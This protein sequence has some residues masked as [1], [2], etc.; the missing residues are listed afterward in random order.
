MRADRTSG[1]NDDC[2]LKEPLEH[3]A[4]RSPA[5]LR[6]QL[7][8]FHDEA[9]VFS[10]QMSV[11]A[12]VVIYSN[13]FLSTKVNHL[14]PE[15]FDGGFAEGIEKKNYRSLAGKIL[16]SV[17]GDDFDVAVFSQPLLRLGGYLRV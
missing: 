5:I 13:L 15:P 16:D 12:I 14:V 1:P 10:E 17:A 6:D 11:N 8:I 3:L 4:T 9:D 2:R 7:A